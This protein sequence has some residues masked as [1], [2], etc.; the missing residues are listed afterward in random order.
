MC[1]QRIHVACRRWR[2]LVLASGPAG[3]PAC[4]RSPCGRQGR[5]HIPARPWPTATTPCCPH[6]RCVCA[7]ARR[8]LCAGGALM[9]CPP[10]VALGSVRE[11][12]S[13]QAGASDPRCAHITRCTGSL[14]MC[15]TQHRGALGRL[16]PTGLLSE[17]RTAP[18]AQGCARAGS[19]ADVH[20]RRRGSRAGSRCRHHPHVRRVL[21]CALALALA[22]A[23]GTALAWLLGRLG[24]GG[25]L[26]LGL[27]LRCPPQLC[28]LLF[29]LAGL[30]GP[31]EESRRR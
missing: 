17:A 16:H 25:W 2:L 9:Y 14:Y 13:G 20:G 27:A 6:I 5:W 30:P 3:P 31:T 23:I 29:H 26:G 19:R 22:L 7:C 4:T 21:V 18:H 10:L 1:R 8:S 15:L 24:G 11:A 12:G 28:L